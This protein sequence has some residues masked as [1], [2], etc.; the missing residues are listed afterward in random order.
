MRLLDRYLLRELLVPFGYC[1][2][3]FLVF[4]ISSDIFTQLSDFQKFRLHLVD[5]LEL[6]LV[7]TPEMLVTVLPV[8]FL[9]ALLYTLTT[10]AR[11]HE[12]T[13]IRAAGVSLLRL[14]VPYLATGFLLS[15]GVFALNELWVPQSLEAADD[16][17]ARREP[18]R[19]NPG[20]RQWEQQL[21]FYNPQEQRWWLIASYNLTTAEMIKPHITWLRPDGS[22]LEILAE[23]GGRIDGVWTFTNAN[24][25]VYP[26][27]QGVVP[28][29]RE[30]DLVLMPM[31]AETPEQI[32]SE[33]RINKLTNFKSVRKTQLSIQEI[34]EYQRLRPGGTNKDDILNTKLHGRLAAPWACLV[35]VLIALPFGIAT[36]RRNVVVGVASSI[37]IC[38]VYF[39]F[40]QLA[41]ALG[42]GGYVRP[43][44]AAW[45]PN[46][47][48]ALTGLVL[49]WRV[50]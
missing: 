49:I 6:Y 27:G 16:I 35:V 5:V 38:F 31:F 10:H 37:M 25:L 32:R 34:L 28:E 24:V 26:P 19:S 22:R 3:G 46:A 33:I 47:L 42:T 17:L 18:G 15:L 4:W 30:E 1:L 45:A 40:Q 23:G 13:A 8:A 7:K 21:G 29:H 36:G 14:S 43:W 20:K 41:L 11:H 12:L 39:V 48:F 9:L 2:V 50:R 44:M